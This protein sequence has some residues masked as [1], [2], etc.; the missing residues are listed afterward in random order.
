M[1]TAGPQVEVIIPIFILVALELSGM[2]RSIELRPAGR[3][4][5][6]EPVPVLNQIFFFYSYLGITKLPE[7]FNL[8][9]ML[10]NGLLV[11]GIWLIDQYVTGSSARVLAVPLGAFLVVLPILEVEEYREALHQSMQ[12]SSFPFHATSMTVSGILWLITGGNWIIHLFMSLVIPIFY[13][14]LLYKEMRQ[15]RLNARVSA[16]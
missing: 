12:I 7:R 4:T 16:K 3:N 9:H 8:I 11:W 15:L 13:L 2:A 5:P 1:P 10:N 14:R 6:S